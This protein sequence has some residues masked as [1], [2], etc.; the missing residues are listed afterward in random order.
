MFPFTLRQIE[1]FQVICESGSFRAAADKLRISQPTVSQQ[2]GVLERQLGFDLFDRWRGERVKLTISGTRF[3]KS[4]EEFIRAGQK[5]ASQKRIDAEKKQNRLHIY[6]GSH[7]LEDFVRPNM[8]RFYEICDEIELI[9]VSGNPRI[10]C[11]DEFIKRKI[12]IGVFMTPDWQD[13]KHVVGLEMICLVSAGIYGHKKYMLDG[14]DA[15]VVSNLPFMMPP[16]RTLEEEKTLQYLATKE[17]FP[18]KIVVRSSYHDVDRQLWK[19]GKAVGFGMETI[20]RSLFP[21]VICLLPFDPWATVFYRG[22]DVDDQL[23]SRLKEAILDC[24]KGG[25]S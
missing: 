1:I 24:M 20:T 16:R 25:V 22:P 3:Q 23:A 14:L 5:L 21:E 15:M 4:A 7:I 6:I 18:S 12:D 10:Y 9:F 2:I 19:S 8:S 11:A 17:I 13:N